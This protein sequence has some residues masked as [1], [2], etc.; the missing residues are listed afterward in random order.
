[1]HDLSVTKINKDA[2]I[3]LLLSLSPLAKYWDF[4]QNRKHNIVKFLENYRLPFPLPP[5]ASPSAPAH[6]QKDAG[7]TNLLG[8]IF[9]SP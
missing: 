9:F 1:M 6:T 4:V 5:S 2:R 7:E 8:A 3:S